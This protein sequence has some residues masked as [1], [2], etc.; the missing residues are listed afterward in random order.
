MWHICRKLNIWPQVVSLTFCNM[1]VDLVSSEV[2]CDTSSCQKELLIV[3]RHFTIHEA[4]MHDAA[5]TKCSPALPLTNFVTLTF[6]I[7]TFIGLIW[8]WHIVLPR[9]T[10][11][12]KQ[13]QNTLI[14]DRFKA[15]QSKSSNLFTF[16]PS[17][18]PWPLRYE[19]GFMWM[20]RSRIFYQGMVGGGV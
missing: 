2:M 18:W 6:E 19:P 1:K 11:C 16:N 12:A 7:L 9:R 4:S 8:A 15:C 20:H 13:I 3:P 10:F 17:L 5:R 14:H